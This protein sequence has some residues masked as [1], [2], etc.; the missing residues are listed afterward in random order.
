MPDKQT[1]AILGCGW[2]GLPLAK[3]LLAEGYTVK[4]STTAAGKLPHLQDAGI[5][6]YL[7]SLSEKGITGSVAGFLEGAGVLIID[8]PPK[9]KGGESYPGKMRHLIPYVTNA[10]IGKVL[11]VSSTSVYADDNSIVTEDTRPNPD[12]ESGKQ[13][14]EAEM[15]LKMALP[16]TT[17]LRFG[18]LFG[19]DRHPV[20]HLAGREN[21]AAPDAPVNLIHR[22]DCIGIIKAIIQKQAWG[23]VFNGVAPAH[24]T[25]KE[26]YTAKAAELGLENP[27]FDHA[28]VLA[29]KIVTSANI[30]GVL[31][32]AYKK[33]L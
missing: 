13:L 14:L 22:D 26:Y 27:K 21:L 20:F 8:V 16:E 23:Q 12:S 24:P 32:Y 7:V 29:G 33:S 15:L 31:G 1:I 5:A 19:G 17:V 2:L 6:P 11:L 4:G 30:H 9:V 10:K 25:R 18:G 28:E 3:A